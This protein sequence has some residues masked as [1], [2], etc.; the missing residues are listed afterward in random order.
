VRAVRPRVLGLAVLKSRLRVL[1]STDEHGIMK[2]GAVQLSA[3]LRGV[4]PPVT[5]R[6][7]GAEQ[8]SLAELKAITWPEPA[9]GRLLP[10]MTSNHPSWHEGA[11]DAFT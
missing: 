11:L 5:R 2:L 9:R 7:R 3:R 4:S 6:P 10:T 8:T 1:G